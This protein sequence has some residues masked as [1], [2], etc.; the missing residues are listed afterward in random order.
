M[1]LNEKEYE[2]LKFLWKESKDI[3]RFLKWDIKAD[4]EYN[5]LIRKGLCP[6]NEQEFYDKKSQ[7]LGLR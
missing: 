6:R 5:F 1:T 4:M 3:N 7:E 2:R